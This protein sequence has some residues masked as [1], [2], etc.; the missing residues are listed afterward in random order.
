MNRYTIVN[1]KFIPAAEASV[2]ITDLALQRG[3]GIFD[4]FKTLDGQFKFLE[5]HLDR[6]Y[7]S[8]AAMHLP[9]AQ[10]REALKALL[11]AL[12]E[13]NNIPNSGIRITLT[14][15]Y[16]P[17]GYTLASPNMIITQ[18]PLVNPEF[19]VKGI[20]LMT[21]PHQRQLAQV[22][23]LDYL[24]AIYLQPLIKQHGA[25]DVLYHHNGFV[26]ECPRSNFFIVTA[27]NEVVT[28]GKDV[29]RGVVRKQLLKMHNSELS[30]TEREISLEDLKTCE[31]A[32]IASSTK[33]VLPVTTIDG[34]QIG[35]GNAGE[36]TTLLAEKFKAL[37]F[38]VDSLTL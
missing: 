24:M 26:K 17:D 37:V 9:V 27:H 29:L 20:K 35:N 33:N 34:H 21:Y 8:A 18:N 4:F 19:N 13:K 2:L 30:I 16:S 7:H 15:G 1:D 22:K 31:E 3:Y 28:S 11:C 25:D 38:N 6:F 23:T 32:F 14:G 12:Q 36:I 10:T 5:D